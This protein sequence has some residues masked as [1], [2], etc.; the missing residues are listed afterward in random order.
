[1][2]LPFQHSKQ[3]R[4]TPR[5]RHQASNP[6]HLGRGGKFQ[7]LGDLVCGL[8]AAARPHVSPGREHVPPRETLPW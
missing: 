6:R 5:C 8:C 1:M 4:P 2:N 3:E 7:K